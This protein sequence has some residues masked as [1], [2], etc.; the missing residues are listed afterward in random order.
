VTSAPT[1]ASALARRTSWA[2]VLS[3]GVAFRGPMGAL[4]PGDPVSER[5]VRHSRGLGGHVVEGSRPDEGQDGMGDG[6]SEGHRPGWPASP[7]ELGGARLSC[8]VCAHLGGMG[9]VP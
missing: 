3:L 4:A 2:N 8:A 6:L 9:G 5:P 1:L 7:P